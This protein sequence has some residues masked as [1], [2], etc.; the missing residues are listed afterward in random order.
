MNVED[1][2]KRF[3]PNKEK[4]NSILTTGG[5]VTNILKCFQK[6]K[7]RF[8]RDVIASN[9]L[10]PTSTMQ[11]TEMPDELFINKKITTVNIILQ[12]NDGVEN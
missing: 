3:L 2:H 4:Q 11:C 8:F 6:T 1:N 9:I 10:L 5:V 7:K 12:S